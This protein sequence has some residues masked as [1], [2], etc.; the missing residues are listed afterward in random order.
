MGGDGELLGQVALAED[1]HLD[2]RVPDQAG[3]REH[4]RRHLGVGIEALEV[5]DVDCGHD[6]PVRAA[7]HCILRVGTALLSQSHVDRRLP[8]LETRAHLVRA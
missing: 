1:L 4:L 8:A 5:A 6:R 7:R 3:F 2:A